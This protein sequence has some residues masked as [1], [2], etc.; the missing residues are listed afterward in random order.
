MCLALTFY[1]V[2]LLEPLHASGGI[3]HAPLAGKERMA[4]AA[5]FHP[6]FLLGGTGGEF[7]AAGTNDYGIIKVLGMY[8]LFHNV[9]SV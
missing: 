5:D 2:A 4:I 8:F 7:I 3:H 1:A 9:Q 6:E